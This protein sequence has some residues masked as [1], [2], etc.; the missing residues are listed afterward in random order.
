MELYKCVCGFVHVILCFSYCAVQGLMNSV[1]RVSSSLLRRNWLICTLVES[2]LLGSV[3]LFILEKAAN[4]AFIQWAMQQG[5]EIT[6]FARHKCNCHTITGFL[7]FYSLIA[8]FF[9]YGFNSWASQTKVEHKT[10]YSWRSGNYTTG[11]SKQRVQ[12]SQGI[13]VMVQICWSL[14]WWSD[15]LSW[16]W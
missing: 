6:I 1:S 7:R 5:K 9:L 10:E 16:W 14:W 13:L 4:T 15:P 2:D 3:L 11:R 8:I 12:H